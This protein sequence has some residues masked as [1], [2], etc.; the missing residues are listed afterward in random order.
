MEFINFDKKDSN[1]IAR[2][3]GK[4]YQVVGVGLTESEAAKDLMLKIEKCKF[5]LNFLNRKREGQNV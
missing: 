1:Y 3:N 2:I 4:H 5:I